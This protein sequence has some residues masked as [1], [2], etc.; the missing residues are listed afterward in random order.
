[1]NLR[2]TVSAAALALSASVFAQF[3]PNMDYTSLPP[4]PTE[5]EQQLS[6]ASLSLSAAISKA[7]QAAGGSTVS[8]GSSSAP[9]R[10]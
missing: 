1:M 9:L 2:R 10:S 3:N 4:E 5:V 7:E 6:A 8:G